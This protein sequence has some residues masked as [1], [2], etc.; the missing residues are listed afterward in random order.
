M[1][2]GT[3]SLITSSK[4]AMSALGQ[5]C[6]SDNVCLIHTQATRSCFTLLNVKQASHAQPKSAQLQ[7]AGGL[8]KFVATTP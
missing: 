2:S 7:P 4:L 1:P 5:A 3:S 8:A 6:A